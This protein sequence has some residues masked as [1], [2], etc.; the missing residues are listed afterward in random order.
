MNSVGFR[1]P[2]HTAAKVITTCQV[3]PSTST[4][5]SKPNPG[6]SYHCKLSEAVWY[7]VPFCRILPCAA[8]QQAGLLLTMARMYDITCST[9]LTCPM[10]VVAITGRLDS[11]IV[12]FYAIP[13]NCLVTPLT[14]V[15]SNAQPCGFKL[16]S[17]TVTRSRRLLQCSEQFA[18]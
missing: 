3:K 7:S 17:H 1:K 12:A 18:V 8:C 16:A 10:L 13:R 14:A 9:V 6:T 11:F 4:W 5:N 15:C 2:N